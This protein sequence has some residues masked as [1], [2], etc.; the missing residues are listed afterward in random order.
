ME[1]TP[2][3]DMAYDATITVGTE[4]GNAI[5]VTIQLKD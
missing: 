3:V 2:I 4:S 1:W 5:A